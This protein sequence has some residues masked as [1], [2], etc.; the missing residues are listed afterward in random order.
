MKKIYLF[1]L[2][3]TLASVGFAGK[4]AVLQEL[5]KPNALVVDRD[6]LFVTE[7]ATIYIYSLKDFTLQKKFGSEGEGPREFK[8]GAS[9]LALPDRL[10]INSINKVSFFTR[11]G[12]FIKE[13]RLE[14]SFLELYPF[15]ENFVGM[16]NAT[17]NKKRYTLF[18]IYD[19]NF[20]K[21]KE[22]HRAEFFFQPM[23]GK[24]DPIAMAGPDGGSGRSPVFGNKF[25]LGGDEGVMDIFDIKGN[26]LYSINLE[27]EKLKFTENDKKRYLNFFKTHPNTR[28]RF[29]VLKKMFTFPDYFPLIRNAFITDNKIYIRTYKIKNGKSRFYIFD[30]KGKLLKKVFLP[31][32]EMNAID[33]NPYTIKNGKI[34]QLIENF[35]E[36]EWELHVTALPTTD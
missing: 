18:N 16:V 13:I 12:K 11:D 4:E 19:S 14:T 3:I 17:E 7:G 35:D 24:V 21:V 1:I 22:I 8:G 25:F 32:A 34:Y 29:E 31:I 10:L 5:N 26:K 2:F 36:E 30:L 15:G 27:I 33:K 9:L 23:R 28:E 20:E 6:K